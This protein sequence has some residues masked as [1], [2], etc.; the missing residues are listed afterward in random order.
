L[1][2]A[3]QKMRRNEPT[4][5]S[6][7]HRGPDDVTPSSLPAPSRAPQARTIIVTSGCFKEVV[8]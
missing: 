2:G 4:T 1:G 5:S 3:A 7:I 6:A 8:A